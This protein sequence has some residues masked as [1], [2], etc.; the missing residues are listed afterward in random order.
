VQVRGLE[1]LSQVGSD[2]HFSLND[3]PAGTYD[4]Q[5][6]STAPQTRPFVFDSVK[7]ISGETVTVPLSGWTFSKKLVLNTTVSGAAVSNNVVHFP[8]LVR[9]TKSNFVFSEAA[10]DGRD[11]RFAK[12][13]NAPLPYEIERWDSANGLAEVWV[14]V[15]TVYGNDGTHFITMFWGNASAGPATSGPGVFDTANGF[16]GVWHLGTAAGTLARDATA[17][18]YDGTLSD[19]APVPTPG[20]IGMAYSFDGVSNAILL[21]NTASSTLNFPQNGFYSISA[22]V[23]ADTLD[24]TPSDSSYTTDMTIVSK[25]NC[26][27]AL[28]TR[29]ADWEFFE[30][31]S[32]SGWQG[33]ITPAAQR[34]WQHVVGVRQGTQQFLYVNGVCMVDSVTWLQPRADARTT[35]DDV[36]IGKMP[37]KWFPTDTFD[38]PGHYFNGKI[39]EVRISSISLS[40][41][42]IKLCYMNQK[43]QDALIQW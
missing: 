17:N 33:T 36:A 23:Y 14:C 29:S 22:W 12:Q 34:S 9:L 5:I 3:L 21:K 6:S 4:F 2:E 31:A 13:D 27:Y 20:T 25:D 24:F 42:W 8:V 16:Q 30:Y 28:K 19:T 1:R 11:M 15:D 26:Q 38:G 10:G 35:V 43:P 39:D 37:G 41:A 40:A 32:H 7:A 18:H